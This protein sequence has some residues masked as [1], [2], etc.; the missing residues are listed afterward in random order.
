MVAGTLTSNAKEIHKV[1][2]VNIT[3]D[4][5]KNEVYIDID[6]LAKYLKAIKQ[7]NLAY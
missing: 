1:L 7:N 2:D 5:E 3:Y 4:K 6:S